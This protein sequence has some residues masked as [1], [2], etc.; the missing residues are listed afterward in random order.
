MHQS[1]GKSEIM[2]EKVSKVQKPYFLRYT[3]VVVGQDTY[4]RGLYK[5]RERIVDEIMEIGG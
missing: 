3:R 5:E 1:F 2:T 4:I